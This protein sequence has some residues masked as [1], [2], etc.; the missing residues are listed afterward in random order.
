MLI[1]P[2]AVQKRAVGRII[3]WVEEEGF[4]IEGVRMLGLTREQAEQFYAEHRERPFFTSLVAFMTS[5]PIVALLLR[6][7][8]AVRVLRLLIG[9]TDS[10]KADEGTIRAAFGIDNQMNAVHASDSPASAARETAFFFS[11]LDRIRVDEG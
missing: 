8:D 7:D 3:A 2:D 10:R 9:S 1:K 11:A 5:G 6:R 4:A